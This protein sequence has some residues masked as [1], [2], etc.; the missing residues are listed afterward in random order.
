MLARCS[1]APGSMNVDSSHSELV[2][3]VGSDV[4]HLDPLLSGLTKRDTQRISPGEWGGGVVR[5]HTHNHSP[6]V[7][8]APVVLWSSIMILDVITRENNNFPA[9]FYR[10]KIL[11]QKPDNSNDVFQVL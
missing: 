5:V 1:E 10:H 11:K 9:K 6:C 4:S 7:C 2:P 8:T 3:P